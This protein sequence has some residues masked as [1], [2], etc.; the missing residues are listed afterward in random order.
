LLSLFSSIFGTLVPGAIYLKQSL[1]FRLPVHVDEPVVGRVDI[2][3]VRPFRRRGVIVT[4][5]TKVLQHRQ[6]PQDDEPQGDLQEIV[7]VMGS[8]DVWLPGGTQQK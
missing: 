3:R 1:D 5:D 8:A 2:T 4:C 6:Q 7:Y